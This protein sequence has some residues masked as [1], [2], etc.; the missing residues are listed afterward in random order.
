WDP[1]LPAPG[2][3]IPEPVAIHGSS[4]RV[5]ALAVGRFFGRRIVQRH[6]QHAMA[7]AKERVW[8][9]AAYFIPNRTLRGALRR[10]ARRGVDVRVMVPRNLDVV[11]LAHAS[12]YTWGKL[13]K[14]GV[15]IF[16]WTKGM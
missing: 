9:E 14:S 12:R 2:R 3:R 6:L 4:T 16:E 10:A 5:Q 1:A 11:G 13:L 7:M 15:Q 8:I